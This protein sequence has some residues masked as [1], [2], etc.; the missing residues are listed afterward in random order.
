MPAITSTD[1]FELLNEIQLALCQADTKLCSFWSLVP[2]FLWGVVVAKTLI[3]FD[4]SGS[5]YSDIPLP[6][7][8]QCVKV[9]EHRLPLFSITLFFFKK[10]QMIMRGFF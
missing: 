10:N 5:V 8:A 4:S 6:V 2:S 9:P 1:S 3:S 7:G